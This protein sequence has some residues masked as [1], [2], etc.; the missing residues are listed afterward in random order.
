VGLFSICPGAVLDYIPRQWVR[1]LHVV[2]VAHLL[3][4]QVYTGRF[5]IGLQADTSWDWIQHSGAQG[6]FP[7]GPGGH[8]V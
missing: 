3:G 8:R 4:L 5:E 7:Q 2:C 6:D 1:E